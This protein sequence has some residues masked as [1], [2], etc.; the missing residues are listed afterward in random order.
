MRI[1]KWICAFILI[2]QSAFASSEIYVQAMMD[3][4]SKIEYAKTAKAPQ[5]KGFFKTH[6]VLFFFSSR[7]PYC[8]QFAP[9]VKQYIENNKAEVLALSFDNRPL[10]TF[11]NF[12]PASKN[13]VS[14]AFGNKPIN[15]PALFIVNPKTHSVYPVSSGAYS[16][17]ELDQMMNSVIE[18]IQ[19]YEARQS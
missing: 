8:L 2:S 18:Q 19:N 4:K 10:P 11:P 14:L 7:C 17:V 1:I 15:Y 12:I 9:V 6:G 16:Y 13:W 3:R 5:G